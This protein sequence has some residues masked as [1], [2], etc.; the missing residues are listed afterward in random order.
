M[1]ETGIKFENIYKTSIEKIG[2]KSVNVRTFGKDKLK[3]SAVLCILGNG[4]KLPPLLIFRGKKNGPIENDLKNNKHVKK[5]EIFAKCQ[6]NAWSDHE[7]F[8]YWLNNIWF[9]SSI[10]KSIKNS[11]LT[12]DRATT[13]FDNELTNEFNKEKQT[14][15]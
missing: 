10:Y 8:L 15:Y 4:C 12:L 7:I 13:D 6:E 9:S 11:I 5:G 1:D 14:M 2:E 3:I